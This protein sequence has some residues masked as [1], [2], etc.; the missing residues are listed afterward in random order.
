MNLFNGLLM[1]CALQ[2]HSTK[3]SEATFKAKKQECIRIVTTCIRQE[4]GDN[5]TDN[6]VAS[7][8]DKYNKL[9]RPNWECEN[10]L[11]GQ[12]VK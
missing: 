2:P 12:C 7:C 3:M 10:D 4:Y 6:S 5:W 11:D 9:H 8:M 1:F